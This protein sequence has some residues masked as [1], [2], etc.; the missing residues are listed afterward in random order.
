VR[1]VKL[2]TKGGEISEEGLK[3]DY[4]KDDTREESRIALTYQINMANTEDK[5]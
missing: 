2:F 3:L 4:H 1:L 5:E